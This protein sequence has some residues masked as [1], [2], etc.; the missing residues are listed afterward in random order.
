[1]KASL[2]PKEQQIENLKER[3]LDLEKVFEK[4]S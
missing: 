3:L 4:Q 1:M 2:E